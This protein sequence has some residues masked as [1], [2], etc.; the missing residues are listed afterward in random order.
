MM[1]RPLSASDR[2][3]LTLGA[4]V[5]LPVLAYTLVARPYQHALSDAR[6]R[7]RDERALLA[8]EQRLVTEAPDYPRRRLRAGQALGAT[9]TR[10]VRGPDTL[11]V[12]AALA[13]QV[14]DAAAGAGMLVEQVETHGSDSLRLAALERVRL[15]AATVDLRA[16][17]DLHGA[18]AFLDALETGETLV[19]IDRLR[20]ERAPAAT[21]AADQETLSVSVTV[22][23]I[24]RVLSRPPSGPP[25]SAYAN[26]RHTSASSSGA[27]DSAD[28]RRAP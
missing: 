28:S 21:D 20:I 6:E 9:W 25:R 17:G 7:L 18:L 13:S 1:R 2:R 16:R 11:S 12:A 14:T 3:A 27:P 19:R 24:A 5:V 23:G 15:G 10:L 26:R 8:R 22:S 4:F